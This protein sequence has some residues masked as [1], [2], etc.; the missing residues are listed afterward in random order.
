MQRQLIRCCGSFKAEGVLMGPNGAWH[1]EGLGGS[2][3]GVQEGYPP[4]KDWR[5]NRSTGS[6]LDR[7]SLVLG[8]S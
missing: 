4:A 7:D 1:E 8:L 6:R 5:G 2:K 3:R